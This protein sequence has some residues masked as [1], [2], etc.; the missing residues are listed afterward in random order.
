[1]DHNLYQIIVYRLSEYEDTK[2]ICLTFGILVVAYGVNFL[3]S[4]ACIQS[5][6]INLKYCKTDKVRECDYFANTRTSIAP[7]NLSHAIY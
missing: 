2:L 3:H 5:G 4:L 6:T 1:M 7:A